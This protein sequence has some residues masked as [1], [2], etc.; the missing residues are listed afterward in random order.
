[1]LPCA[2]R[3]S[4]GAAG[5]PAVS[6]RAAGWFDLRPVAGARNVCSPGT[7]KKEKVVTRYLIHT[8]LL[9]SLCC[10]RPAGAAQAGKA[11]SRTEGELWIA[12]NDSIEIAVGTKTG[13]IQRLLDKVSREDYCNQVVSG[14]VPVA[15]TAKEPPSP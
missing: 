6:G 5:L 12:G 10:V 8:A 1:M 13:A 7:V 15:E 2:L 9:C 4:R 11:Y 14:A 3:K